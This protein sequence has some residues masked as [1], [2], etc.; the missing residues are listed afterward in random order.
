M[1]KKDLERCIE[2]HSEIQRLED[3]R[4]KIE[5]AAQRIT[6]IIS[7]EPKGNEPRD[8][9]AEY[10]AKLD[11]LDRL[12]AGKIIELNALFR[13]IELDLEDF[14]AQQRIILKLRYIDGLPWRRVAEKS[15]YSEKHIFKIHE[16]ALLKM[17]T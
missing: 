7:S 13:L 16:A 2:L 1:R 11:T 5:E 12:Y 3:R 9:L 14:P 10:V 15:K 4:K 17:D 8:K 6:K